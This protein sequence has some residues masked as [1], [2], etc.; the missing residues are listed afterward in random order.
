[1]PTRRQSIQGKDSLRPIYE[2]Q[3]KLMKRKTNITAR[4]EQYINTEEFAQRVSGNR[5]KLTRD[6]L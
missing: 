1:L 2:K 4:S 5:A 6:L 3:D